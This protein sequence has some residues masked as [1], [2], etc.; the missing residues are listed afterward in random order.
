METGLFPDFPDDRV[1]QSFTRFD[2]AARQRPVTGER[3]V[4]TLHEQN[5]VALVDESSDTEHRP[6]RIAPAAGIAHFL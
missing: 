4:P 2:A 5:L 1:L 3:R 6:D